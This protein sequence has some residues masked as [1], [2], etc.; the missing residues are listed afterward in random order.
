M[1]PARALAHTDWG[2]PFGLRLD[3]LS[4]RREGLDLAP[5][6]LADIEISS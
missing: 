2:A 4:A 3:A 5:Q 1:P 6:R